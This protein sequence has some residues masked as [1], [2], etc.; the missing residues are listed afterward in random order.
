M[1]MVRVK[2]N[3]PVMGWTPGEIV[4]I[5]RSRMVEGLIT[6]EHITVLDE[7]VP[8]YRPDDGAAPTEYTHGLERAAASK[9][10][11]AWALSLPPASSLPLSLPPTLSLP[12]ADAPPTV[13]DFARAAENAPPVSGAAVSAQLGVGVVVVP[14]RTGTGSGVAAWRAFLDS[15]TLEY[16]ADYTRDQL[17]EVWDCRSALGDHHTD[18]R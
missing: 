5:E 15:Q 7:D 4:E 8:D 10:G 2:V 12:P 11:E 6:N 1:A 17:I 18:G 14:P 9:L 16:P 13:E 3:S